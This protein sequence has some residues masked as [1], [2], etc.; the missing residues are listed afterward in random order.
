M[1]LSILG[2]IDNVLRDTTFNTV[3]AGY[4]LVTPRAA[5]AQEGH[6]G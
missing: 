1:T 3:P 2:F 6:A 5:V 4:K